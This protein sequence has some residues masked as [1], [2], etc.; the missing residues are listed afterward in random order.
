MTVRAPQDLGKLSAPLGLKPDEAGLSPGA[1]LQR[2][3][4][5]LPDDLADLEPT[6]EAF[7]RWKIFDRLTWPTWLQSRG[8][9]SGAVTLMMVGGDSRELSALY[10]LRQIMLLRKSD[11]FYKIQGGMD[12]LPRALA[13]R[14]DGKVTYEAAVTRLDP[15]AAAVRVEY[16][17]GQ[18]FKAI[19]ARRVI[20]AIPCSTL[21]RIDLGMLV[22]PSK[23]AAIAALPY[24]PAT[25]FLLQSRSRFWEEAG[26]SGSARTDQPAEIWDCTYDL[27]ADRGVLGAT[28][29]GAMGEPVRRLSQAQTVRFGVDLVAATFGGLATQFE[30]GTAIRWAQ[31]P[32]SRGAFA[33]FHPD[34][35]TAMMPMIGQPEGR[36]HFAGEHTSSWMGWME[37]ALESGERAAREVLA[38]ESGSAFPQR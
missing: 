5:D 13:R 18:A 21:R 35:M 30:K 25:R 29:G 20:L 37:G 32:W 3:L 11:Q 16:R 12:R 6:A 24:F 23:A 2:Y 1:L 4:G 14:L 33:V 8:A 7:S 31:E 27:P 26:L 17:H 36:L 15:V 28:V 38:S 22:S 19:R 9:S 10:V 34:Q